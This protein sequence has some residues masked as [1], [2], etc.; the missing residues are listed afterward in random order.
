MV[1]S[2]TRPGWSCLST[3]LA[4][5]WDVC[6]FY[7]AVLYFLFQFVHMVIEYPLRLAYGIPCCLASGKVGLC[8]FDFFGTGDV[9]DFLVNMLT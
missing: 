6:A 5:T 1:S 4:S 2:F 3:P 9:V 7:W 8:A